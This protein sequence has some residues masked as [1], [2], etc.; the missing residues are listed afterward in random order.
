MLQQKIICILGMK[1]LLATEKLNKFHT[2]KYNK[3]MPEVSSPLSHLSTQAIH[4]N[5]LHSNPLVGTF[6]IKRPYAD[7]DLFYLDYFWY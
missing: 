7:L 2:R 1:V 5:L 4:G 3:V 6:R